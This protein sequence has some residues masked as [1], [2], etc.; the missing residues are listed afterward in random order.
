MARTEETGE[1]SVGMQVIG[2][3]RRGFSSGISANSGGVWDFESPS[4]RDVWH[5]A[6]LGRHARHCLLLTNVRVLFYRVINTVT[7]RPSPTAPSRRRLGMSNPTM[8]GIRE[9]PFTMGNRMA[10]SSK[11]LPSPFCKQTREKDPAPPPRFPSPRPS[12][13]GPL[14]PPVSPK[15]PPRIFLDPEKAGGPSPQAPIPAPAA[16]PVSPSQAR[17]P[18][19]SRRAK[20][21][22][23]PPPRGPL[24]PMTAS[25][26]PI[27]STA[28]C[29][30]R[31][32]S[33]G[34][35]AWQYVM[36]V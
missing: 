28:S 19:R 24:G 6:P 23:Q 25:S 15:S 7:G 26:F 17:N 22:P 3:D 34:E 33:P 1:A 10:L 12:A 5:P 27:G 13:S 29:T 35:L 2:A 36:Q 30:P 31:S 11:F 16:T 21:H 18:Q 4:A 14:H 20:V 9:A 32:R 8:Q